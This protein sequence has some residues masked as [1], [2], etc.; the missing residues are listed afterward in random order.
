MDELIEEIKQRVGELDAGDGYV[1]K[2][3]RP[4]K[5]LTSK[6]LAARSKGKAAKRRRERPMPIV[7]PW[8][9]ATCGH[10]IQVAICL[11][12]RIEGQKRTDLT[13]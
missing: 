4:P 8:R 3:G 6:Q 11:E 7:D 2:V 10:L 9:C 12:C 5:N 1:V 13:E